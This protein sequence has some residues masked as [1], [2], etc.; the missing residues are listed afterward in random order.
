[1]RLKVTEKKLFLIMIFRVS[2]FGVVS[3]LQLALYIKSVP[4]I[5]KMTAK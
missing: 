1:M 3:F 5:P 2:R 4:I